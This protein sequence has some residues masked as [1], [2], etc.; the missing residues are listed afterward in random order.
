MLLVMGIYFI[1]LYDF[2]GL[3]FLLCCTICLPLASLVLLVPKA[4]LCK[5]SMGAEQTFVTRGEIV[6]INIKVEN[7]GV[8]PISRLRMRIRWNPPGEREMTVKKWVYGFGRGYEEVTLELSASH[9]GEA[10]F[11]IVKAGICD[12]LGIFLL[13]VK[14]ANSAKF[15]VT[16]VI[17]PIIGE[18]KELLEVFSRIT[19]GKQEGDVALR[20]YRWGDSMQKVYWKL[21]AKL[22]ELQVREVER[23]HSVVLYLKYSELFKS[24]GREWDQYLDRACSLLYFLAE[25]HKDIGMKPE[26]VWHHKDGCWKCEIDNVETLQ[27]WVCALLTQEEVGIPVP[28]EEIPFLEQGCHLDEDCKVYFGEQCVYE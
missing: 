21:A 28:E 11:S 13:P 7:R 8:F 6:R 10:S 20:E 1:M 5:V 25:E 15:C 22:E 17:T 18:D 26:V 27:H 24:R 4:F 16:P 3:R 19:E 14:A 2:P 12:Y 9:C 23:N